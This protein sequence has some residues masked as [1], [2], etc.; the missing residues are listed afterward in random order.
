[1]DPRDPYVAYY[2]ATCYEEASREK[3]IEWHRKAIELDPLFRTPYYRLFDLS[4]RA[5]QMDEA[6]RYLQEFEKLKNHPRAF[7]C[8]FKHTLIGPKEMPIRLD[9]EMARPTPVPA[10]ELFAVPQPLLA[11]ASPRPWSLE[12]QRANVTIADL[13]GQGKM[14]VLIAGVADGQSGNVVLQKT[15]GPWNDASSHPLSRVTQVNTALWGDFDNDGLSD[16]YL[17]RRGPNQLWRQTSLNEWE[18]VTDSSQT[19]AGELGRHV[20]AAGRSVGPG[21][22]WFWFARRPLRGS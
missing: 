18:N 4:R 19:G 15:D 10:G 5:R 3:A 2:L 7:V 1:M 11:S 20:P 9:G 17:C 14:L 22:K 13:N 21:W 16:V 12:T 8:D 6:V